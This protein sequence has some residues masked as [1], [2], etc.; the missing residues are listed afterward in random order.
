LDF[1]EKLCKEYYFAS[2]ITYPESNIPLIEASFKE[3]KVLVI[4]DET[5][6]KNCAKNIISQAKLLQ[7][8]K[9]PKLNR[10]LLLFL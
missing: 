4:R 1:C 8:K 9:T 3:G 2:K 7:L 6:V 10:N 5:A